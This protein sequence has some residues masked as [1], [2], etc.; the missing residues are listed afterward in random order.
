MNLG[1]NMPLKRADELK[2]VRIEGI[3]LMR[4]YR[5]VNFNLEGSLSS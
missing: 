1:L 2:A 3:N 5:I 4:F